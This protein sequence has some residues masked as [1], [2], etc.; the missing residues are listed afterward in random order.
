MIPSLQVGNLRLKEIKS[1][2][3]GNLAQNRLT[4]DASRGQLFSSQHSW[5]VA[6]STLTPTFIFPS[7]VD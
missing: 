1:F 7:A 5:V 6:C 3:Q 4:Q 2:A